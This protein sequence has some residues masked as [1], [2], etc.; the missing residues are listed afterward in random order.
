MDRTV[1]PLIMEGDR[2][3]LPDEIMINILKRLPVKSLIRFQCVCKHWEN[4]VKT[5]SFIAD[6]L[7]HST[8][9]NPSLLVQWGGY[10]DFDFQWGHCR[11]FDFQLSVL[12]CD[13]RELEVQKAPLIDSFQSVYVV[14]SSNGLLC[15]LAGDD[16]S[17][18]FVLDKKSERIIR[19]EVFSLSTKSWKEVEFGNLKGIIIGKPEAVSANGAVFWFG[20]KEHGSLDN[21]LIVSFDMANEVFTL[22]PMPPVSFFMKKKLTVYE[23]NLAILCE[24]WNEVTIWKKEIVCKSKGECEVYEESEGEYDEDEDV[25]DGNEIALYMFNPAANEFEMHVKLRYDYEN[26]IF[27]YVESLVSIGNINI[28]EP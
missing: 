18:G 2:A 28:G 3:F 7:G 27:N 22:I 1:M 20:F 19:V 16:S 5:P 15:L 17:S 14:G 4:L 13:M 24:K 23:N 6:H 25:D 12:G 26:E 21:C 8:H 10:R 11:N 9:R